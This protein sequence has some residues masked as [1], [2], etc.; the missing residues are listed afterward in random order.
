MAQAT[1]R[2]R[3]NCTIEITHEC[4]NEDELINYIIDKCPLEFERKVMNIVYEDFEIEEA[5]YSPPEPD[6]DTIPDIKEE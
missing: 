6:E 2:V 5:T 4:E 1:I 3:L